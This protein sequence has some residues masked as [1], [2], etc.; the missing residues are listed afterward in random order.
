[1]QLKRNLKLLIGG[2]TILYIAFPLLLAALV[3]VLAFGMIFSINQAAY[4]DQPP[5]F[6]IF[7]PFV[8]TP[9]AMG[10]GFAGFALQAFYLYHI[11]KNTAALDWMRI[12]GGI[13]VFSL[14]FV[15]MPVYYLVYIWPEQPPEWALQ[16][17][18]ASSSLD[19]NA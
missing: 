7:F 1:M 10:F 17:P 9:C 12:L 11:L 6:F 4:S 16:P 18:A 8:V 2:G 15:A 3:I 5:P 19:G 13:G 14:P